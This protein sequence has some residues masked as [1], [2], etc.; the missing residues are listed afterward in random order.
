MFS[1]TLRIAWSIRLIRHSSHGIEQRICQKRCGRRFV[2][3]SL[4]Q[5]QLSCRVEDEQEKNCRAIRHRF[6]NCQML[7]TL[8]EP[9]CESATSVCL[10]SILPVSIR[11]GTMQVGQP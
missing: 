7:T 6:D 8:S 3:K 5:N 2:W 4:G 10:V 1:C 9:F 11:G